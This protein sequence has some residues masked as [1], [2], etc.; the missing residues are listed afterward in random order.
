MN[1]L[2]IDFQMN[3]LSTKGVKEKLVNENIPKKRKNDESKVS[4]ETNVL[5]KKVKGENDSSHDDEDTKK[6]QDTAAVLFTEGPDKTED[7]EEGNVSDSSK[8]IKKEP[9][10]K[11]RQIRLEQNRKAARESRRRKKVMIEEL[12]RSVIFFSRANTTLKQQ[13]DE[14]HRL[15]LQAQAK[16]ESIENGREQAKE[17]GVSAPSTREPN[18]KVEA[19]KANNEQ[20]KP[21]EADPPKQDESNV[22]TNIPQVEQA[23]QAVAFAQSQQYA[24]MAAATQAMYETQKGFPPAAARAA[25][26]TFASGTP[27]AAPDVSDGKSSSDSAKESAPT[28]KG[29]PKENGTTMEE[30]KTAVSQSIQVTS[31]S[32]APAS[33]TS[34]T[35]NNQQVPNL[36]QMGLN[37]WTF[38]MSMQQQQVNPQLPGGNN[39]N[40]QSFQNALNAFALHQFS[41]MPQFAA[42]SS[43]F[44]GMQYAPNPALLQQQAQAAFMQQMGQFNVGA[45]GNGLAPALTLNNSISHPIPTTSSTKDQMQNVTTPS[46]STS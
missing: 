27:V 1:P 16:V 41:T 14:L 42:F 12:Q 33:S 19:G 31:T 22:Q 30:E 38:L 9:T 36:N 29:L 37:P 39:L 32:Q 13:N 6:T 18:I 23:Q 3:V 35:M 10:P 21:S 17:V 25:A 26:Q 34:I 11:A 45:P 15:L 43:S 28:V 24:A 44:P 7:V 5:E 4:V 40:Y 46:A 8:H 20:A 2:E